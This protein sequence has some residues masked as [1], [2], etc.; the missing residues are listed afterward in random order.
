MTSN[1]KNAAG[2]N[3]AIKAE[4]NAFQVFQ[5]NENKAKDY[6]SN[7]FGLMNVH[8]MDGIVRGTGSVVS[9]AHKSNNLAL[10]KDKSAAHFSFNKGSSTQDYPGSLMG[11]ISLIRQ[12]FLDGNWYKNKPESE[13][14]NLSLAAF[15]EI[16]NYPMI[17]EG[18]DKLSLIHI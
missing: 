5:V 3:A 2:W 17:I 14:T 6:R 12:T 1:A 8:V 9:L 10:L 13:G 15:N 4:Q 11:V 7:G 18:G 16:Q